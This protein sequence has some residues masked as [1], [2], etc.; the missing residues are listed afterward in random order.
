MIVSDY[1]HMLN[2]IGPQRIAQYPEY[3]PTDFN[4]FLDK[5]VT[6][7]LPM[8]NKPGEWYPHYLKDWDEYKRA[9]ENTFHRVSFED[10]K[11]DAFS[12]IKDIANFLDVSLTDEELQQV[13]ERTSFKSLKSNKNDMRSKAGNFFRKGEIG[14]FKNHLTA[15]QESRVEELTN[16]VLKDTEIKFAYN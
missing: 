3:F 12:R 1:Y 10:L 7:A 15:E 4:V 5:M 13:V 2:V 14:D 11:K 6:G 9:H 16:A 8:A